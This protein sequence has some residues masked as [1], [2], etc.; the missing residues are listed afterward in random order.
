[1]AMKLAKDDNRI[2]KDEFEQLLQDI[3]N[4]EG[5]R[6][7]QF[8][9]EDGI[10]NNAKVFSY[11][12]K[13][14]SAKNLN[15]TKDDI[16]QPKSSSQP[17]AFNINVYLE[18]SA[19]MDGYVTGVT[20]F[21]AAIY[22]LLGDF[23]I[24][25][26]CDSLNL[27]YIN[28]S[29]P[30]SKRN[31]LP[32]DIQDFIEK[33]EPSTFR[34]RGGDRSV[35]DLKNVVNTVL[36]TVNDKN[37]AVL[38]SDFVFSPGSGVDAQDY[39]NNQGVGI[40]I[41][42]AEKIKM[43]DLAAVVIQLISNFDG[44]YYNKTNKPI[45]FKGERP[46]YVWI[47][48]SNQ[49]IR[50]ILEKKILNN[51]KGGYLNRFILQSTGEISELNYKIL[52]NPKIGEFSRYELKKQILTDASVSKNNQNKGLFGFSIAVDFGKNIHD[53]N[54][55]LDP[56]NYVLSNPNYELE[57]DPILNKSDLS[58]SGFTHL[59]KLKTSSLR[60]EALEIK[61]VGR[62]PDWVDASSSIDDSNIL[63]ERSEQ[64]KTFG[65][66]YLIE[67]VSDAFYPKSS[68]NVISTFTVTIKKKK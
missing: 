15:I 13:Y 14:Y 58:L 21:E 38:I 56:T 53:D 36:S 65:L 23:K 43:F 66:E 45:R 27:N 46:Y 41:D 2:D 42:F 26:I 33:L 54:Y 61:V 31:A 3:S 63:N 59:M 5:R 52:S 16:W 37:A 57:V 64:Q 19:S 11:L 18:N 17:T 50:S 34:Q 40:K 29:I 24:S 55:F 62:I 4:S 28:N 7:S 60:S 30:Y 1:M 51:I 20:D 22:N 25:Q 8:K 44:L 48:G 39:L 12:F 9:D 32:A 35:S 67:G 10:I 47:L 6:F 68:S 49:Q